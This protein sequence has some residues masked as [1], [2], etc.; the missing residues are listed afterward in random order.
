MMTRRNRIFFGL[1]WA[2]IYFLGAAWLSSSDSAFW[3][4]VASLLYFFAAISLAHAIFGGGD[5]RCPVCGTKGSHKRDRVFEATAKELDKFFK[6]RGTRNPLSG[7]HYTCKACEC[8]FSEADAVSFAEMAEKY[9][10]E[11]ALKE[12]QDFANPTP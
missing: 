10:E 2:V 9:G 1:T 6:T 8:S 5:I 11:F 3:R 7:C 4:F 12:Y